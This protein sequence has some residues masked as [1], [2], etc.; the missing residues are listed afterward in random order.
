MKTKFKSL[1][2]ILGLSRDIGK[3]IKNNKKKL[4]TSMILPLGLFI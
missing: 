4:I 3:S 2:K 1:E